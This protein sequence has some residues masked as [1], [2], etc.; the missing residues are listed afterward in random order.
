MSVKDDKI[1]LQLDYHSR[2][3][4]N[5]TTALQ[6][7]HWGLIWEQF[8]IFDHTIQ[9]R[10]DIESEHDACNYLIGLDLSPEGKGG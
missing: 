6:V 7:F 1:H 2:Y 4:K 9:G 5:P 3:R 8:P 10:L